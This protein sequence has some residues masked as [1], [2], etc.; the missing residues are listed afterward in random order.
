MNPVILQLGP[1]SLHWYGVF[2]VGG[3]VLGTWLA[4]RTAAKAGENP[5]HVWNMLAW[6][7]VIGIIGARLYHVFST[8]ANG[9][10]FE[11]YRQNP[12]EIINFWSG[13]F[14][15][16]GIYGGLV[17]GVL[18][19]AV[20]AWWK[21]LDLL[22][23]LDFIAPNVLLAQ[24]VGR[25]GNFVNQEL[26]GPATNVAW[27]FHINPAFPCQ[28][29]DNLPAGIQ[30]CGTADPLTQETIA[31]YAA[32]GFHPTFF[33][34]AIWNLAAFRHSYLRLQALRRPLPPR[35]RHLALLHRLPAGPLL[36]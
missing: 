30:Y 35:R 34:E 14:R 11:Y 15:G 25:M 17:G 9:I 27:A 5:D 23:Y 32:N 29:P 7:L 10:G 1:F 13:G 22:M 31:W 20:Y 18:A 28:L 36:G 19:I 33:Y 3:A 16:L 26:Y 12:I 8:P 24:A 6:A 4:A 2:I 21:K